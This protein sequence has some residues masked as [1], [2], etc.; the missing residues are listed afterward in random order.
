M[1]FFIGLRAMLGQKSKDKEEM[2]KRGKRKNKWKNKQDTNLVQFST[3]TDGKLKKPFENIKLPP[4][5][6]AQSKP[7]DI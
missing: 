5:R 7:D 3:K 4:P 1:L 2:G 6:E